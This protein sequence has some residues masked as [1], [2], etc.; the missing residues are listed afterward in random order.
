MDAVPSLAPRADFP[1]LDKHTYLNSASIAI[2]AK[3]VREAMARAGLLDE[4]GPENV[5]PSKGEALQVLRG[6]QAPRAE[7]VDP[8]SG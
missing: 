8:V 3:P 1:A 2:M 4:L 7:Y 5:F 6:T